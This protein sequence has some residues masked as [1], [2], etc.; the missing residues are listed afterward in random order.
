MLIL[1]YNSISNV[2]AS[3]TLHPLPASR[4]LK[5]KQS[6]AYDIK[7]TLPRVLFNTTEKRQQLCD[8]LE[9]IDFSLRECNE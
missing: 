9:I 5:K 2:A 3:K 6:E 4:A 7:S 1:G 8:L